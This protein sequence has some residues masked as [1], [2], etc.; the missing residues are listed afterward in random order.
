MNYVR[1]NNQNVHL[2]LGYMV[3]FNSPKY[4][5]KQKRQILGIA[6]SGNSIKIDFPEL[7]NS[8]NISDGRV[9]HV[10]IQ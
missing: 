3:E 1:L 10:I 4:G 8:L 9:V 5:G 7:G 2:Y 6:E